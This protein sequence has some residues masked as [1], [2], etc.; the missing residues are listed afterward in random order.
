MTRRRWVAVTAL[1]VAGVAVAAYGAAGYV[2]Y[3]QVSRVAPDCRGR[4]V[5][6]TPAAWDAGDLSEVWQASG[7]EPGPWQV[8][9][10]EDVRFPS[11]DEGIELHGW[12]LP[13]DA[14]APPTAPLVVVIHGRDS[15]VRDPAVL[16]PAGMLWHAGFAVLLV[17]LRDQGAS[18]IEDGRYAGG[19]DEYR[20]VLGAIDW[21]VER[22]AGG[23]GI[24][25]AGISMGAATALIA[26]GEDPR[27]AAVW[28]DSGFADIVTRI[29]DELDQRGY[30]TILAPAGPL[31]AR[32]VAG[33][34]YDSHT[35]LGAM[36]RLHG[37]RVAIAHGDSDA[38][39]LVKH[40]AALAGAAWAHG[41]VTD[42]WVMP[43]SGHA[44]AMFRDP[45]GYRDRIVAFFRDAVGPAA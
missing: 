9:R 15:C 3:D 28:E 20:D 24:G 1:A 6:A 22:G 45:A 38:A 11:R 43:G 40:A 19:T 42:V 32:L 44:E 2:L 10:W 5:G 37:R 14:P 29:A 34:D 17:D 33:D 26:G 23:G 31:I 13:P 36:E 7:F 41:V 21:A 25:L 27:V 30:P 16:A 4:F 12:W 8:P 39:T 18:D 35:P